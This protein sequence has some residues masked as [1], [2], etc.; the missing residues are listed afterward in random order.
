MGAKS[1]PKLKCNTRNFPEILSSAKITVNM[2]NCCLAG[3]SIRSIRS[4][5]KNILWDFMLVLTNRLKKSKE[6]WGGS[7]RSS[8]DRALTHSSHED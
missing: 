3:F 6:L 4:K 1:V 2:S 8:F 5:V 7:I